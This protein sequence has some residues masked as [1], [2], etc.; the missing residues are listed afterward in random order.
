MTRETLK[1]WRRRKISYFFMVLAVL[2]ARFS[3]LGVGSWIGKIK[4]GKGK[5]P[6]KAALDFGA[7]KYPADI[8]SREFLPHA[9]P[10]P[11]HNISINKHQAFID[12]THLFALSIPLFVVD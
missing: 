6:L 12:A 2:T 1:L 11:P 10:H 9:P 5:Y 8:T 3:F 7:P 4:E